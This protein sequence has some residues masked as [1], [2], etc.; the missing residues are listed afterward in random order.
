M[1]HDHVRV[2][3]TIDSRGRRRGSEM[4]LAGDWRNDLVF[5][6]T[7]PETTKYRV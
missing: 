4:A 3:F 6:A 1:A 2:G 5:A 7:P